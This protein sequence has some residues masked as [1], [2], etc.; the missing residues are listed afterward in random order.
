[1]FGLKLRKRVQNFSFV[2]FEAEQWKR[3]ND[4]DEEIRSMEDTNSNKIN[5]VK[6][7][8]STVLLPLMGF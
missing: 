4:R 6:K 1:M 7:I 2:Y 8:H 3:L 5:E